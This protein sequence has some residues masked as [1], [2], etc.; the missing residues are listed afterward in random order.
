MINANSAYRRVPGMGGHNIM[1]LQYCYHYPHKKPQYYSCTLHLVSRGR[2]GRGS[3]RERHNK[4]FQVTRIII[5]KID[6]LPEL[7]DNPGN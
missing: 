5:I 2:R 3:R 7:L 6:Y 4:L 1:S